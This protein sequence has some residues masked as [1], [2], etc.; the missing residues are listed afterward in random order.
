MYALGDVVS[1][2]YIAARIQE[3]LVC[4]YSGYGTRISFD[5]YITIDK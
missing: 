4:Q 2:N 3:P 5:D 1:E